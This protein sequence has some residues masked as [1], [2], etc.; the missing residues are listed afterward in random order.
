MDTLSPVLFLQPNITRHGWNQE[1]ERKR[2]C[3]ADETSMHS[4]INAS[5]HPCIH[6]FMHPY[7]HISIHPCINSFIH[8]HILIFIHS[9]IHIITLLRFHP[10]LLILCVHS[11]IDSILHSSC[12]GL[13]LLDIKQFLIHA[14]LALFHPSLRR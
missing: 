2:W 14:P 11:V 1:S 3:N 4:F 12:I 5:T 10:S 8:S 6:T 13:A 7:I 9:H